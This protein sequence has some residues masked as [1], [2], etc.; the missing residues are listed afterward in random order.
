MINKINDT[1][2]YI[3]KSSSIFTGNADHTACGS[4]AVKGNRIME[5]GQNLDHLAS[6]DTRMI[7]C[8]DHMILPGFHDSH[9][10]L[11]LAGL[12]Q[13]C[14]NLQ[15]AESEEETAQLVKEFADSRPDDPW[16]LGF[17]WYHVFWKN[18]KNANQ[19]N[20]RQVDPGPPCVPSEL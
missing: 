10:H 9:V 1:A 2:D 16:V 19:K 7:D 15:K 11:M 3:L 18:K 12:F 20:P 6:T 14:V 5:V 4:V 17:T 8:G 13:T